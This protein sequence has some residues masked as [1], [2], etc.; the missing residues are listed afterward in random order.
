MFFLYF[1]FWVIWFRGQKKIKSKILFLTIKVLSIDW[2]ELSKIPSF[3]VLQLSIYFWINNRALLFC[4]INP[5]IYTRIKK[6]RCW[7]LKKMN[8]Y[9][10]QKTIALNEKEFENVSFQILSRQS[11]ILSNQIN[12]SMLLWLQDF[13]SKPLLCIK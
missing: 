10:L 11:N 2:I 7:H 1:F 3:L 12:N 8:P 6:I 13:Y 5:A 9:I 4:A